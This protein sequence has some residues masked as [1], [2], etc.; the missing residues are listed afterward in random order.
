MDRVCHTCGSVNFEPSPLPDQC[1]F[2]DGTVG[3]HPPTQREIEAANHVPLSDM[4][5]RMQEM[6]DHMMSVNFADLEEKMRNAFIYGRSHGKSAMKDIYLDSLFSNDSEAKAD[7]MAA[8]YGSTRSG[9]YTH[10][11]GKPPFQDVQPIMTLDVGPNYIHALTGHF[12]R[13][14]IIIDEAHR[15]PESMWIRES[16]TEPREEPDWKRTRFSSGPETPPSAAKRAKLR[17]KRKKR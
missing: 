2:C 7:Q 12:D 10:E 14:M 13:Q 1:T 5:E 15:F 16:P 9:R 8:M 4:E 3:G 11:T 17:A 6:M